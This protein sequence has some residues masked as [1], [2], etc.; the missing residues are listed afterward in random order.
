MWLLWLALPPIVHELGHW[1]TGRILGYKIK[2][3]RSGLRF[4]WSDPDYRCEAHDIL[5]NQMGFG[6]EF[7]FAFI[8]WRL[9]FF[10]PYFSVAVFHFLAYPWY[11]KTCTDFDNMILNGRIGR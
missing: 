11:A 3:R 6:A 7:L 2:F 9:G 10:L 5:V 4:V 1:V 8:A